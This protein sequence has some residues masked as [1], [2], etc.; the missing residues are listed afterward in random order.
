MP[1][2]LVASATK[3]LTPELLSRIS[4]GLD[5]DPVTLEKAIAGGIP[6]ILAAFTSLVGKPGGAAKLA[7][8]VTQQPPSMLTRVANAAGAP[9]QDDVIDSGLGALT[10]LMGGSNVSMLTNAL[11]KTA[12]IGDAGAKG[13]IGLLSPLVL[14]MLGQQQ[15]SGG[16]DASGLSQLLQSQKTNIARALPS[17]VA[18]QLSGS[19][20]LD[21]VTSMA[22]TARATAERD[23]PT[24]QFNWA[25]PALAVLALGALAWYLFGHHPEQNVATVPPAVIDT[26]VPGA[27]GFIVAEQDVRNWLGRPIFSRDNKKIGEII[28][29][30]RGPNNEVT[31]IYFD[32]GTFLGMG[33]KRYHITASQIDDMKPNGVMV[34]L[35]EAQ[36]KA[37][38]A[39]D[40]K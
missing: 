15:R 14:G 33:A 25:V 28:D 37:L 21:S 7:E 38:P 30:K 2:N 5:I 22:S 39:T 31:D 24:S 4:T 40:N 1:T 6:A 26:T 12:G 34:S 11:D 16:L 17:D 19:G 29:V 36:V 23:Y 35:N 18:K 20:L 27:R 13:V 10:S 3:L 32:S 8:A 9:A